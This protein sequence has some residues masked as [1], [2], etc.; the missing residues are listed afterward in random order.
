MVKSGYRIYYDKY[1]LDYI[2]EFDNTYKEKFINKIIT[3]KL[4]LNSSHLFWYYKYEKS[5][6]KNNNERYTLE[7][8][9]AFFDTLEQLGIII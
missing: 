1:L 8:Q 7:L 2:F 5:L 3:P 9:E 6:F 4:L